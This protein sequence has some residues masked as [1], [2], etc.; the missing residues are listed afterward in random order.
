MLTG[1]ARGG[2]PAWSSNALAG[3]SGL[4]YLE[5]GDFWTQDGVRNSRKYVVSWLLAA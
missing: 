3:A 5:D 1:Q 2:V 4:Y